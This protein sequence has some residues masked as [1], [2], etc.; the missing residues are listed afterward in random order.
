MAGART[1]FHDVVV[2]PKA[3]SVRGR[4]DAVVAPQEIVK[5]PR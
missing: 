4:D 5:H 2:Q 1:S 3:A